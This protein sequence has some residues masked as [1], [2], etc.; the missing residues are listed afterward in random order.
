MP[1]PTTK[2]TF[3]LYES[4]W[5]CASSWVRGTASCRTPSRCAGLDSLAASVPAIPVV[6][7]VSHRASVP[8]RRQAAVV[9]EVLGCCR[10][11]R[12]AA[13][14]HP[15]RGRSPGFRQGLCHSWGS[16]RTDDTAALPAR[17][18]R[19]PAMGRVFLEE[20]LRQAG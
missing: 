16:R 5:S 10:G 19:G 15:A 11:C 6:L 20:Q 13:P 4:S 2:S 3:H 8:C 9:R 17:Q 1:E 7:R 12:G 18:E 14:G